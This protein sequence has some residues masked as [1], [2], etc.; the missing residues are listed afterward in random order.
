M[1]TGLLLLCLLG[2][3]SAM[4]WPDMEQELAGDFASGE[5]S[6]DPPSRPPP[7]SPPPPTPSGPS[8]VSLAFTAMG[9]VSDYNASVREDL[10]TTFA[11]K[12]AVSPDDVTITITSGSVVITVQIKTTSAAASDSVIAALAPSVSTKAALTSFLS[13]VGGGI[14]VT[15][16]DSALSVAADPSPKS[17]LSAGALAGIII[18]SVVGGLILLFILYKVYVNLM[19]APGR[20]PLNAYSSGREVETV[21]VGITANKH[22]NLDVI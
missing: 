9:D 13:T 6:G 16:I 3:A 1:M 2:R 15:K 11:G 4:S 21:Q 18:G 5:G 17:G 8:T 14:K 22:G 12:A 10:V 19:N 20:A 7:A